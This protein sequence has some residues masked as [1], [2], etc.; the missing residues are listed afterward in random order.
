MPIPKLI[1]EFLDGKQIWYQHCTHSPA[2]TAQGTA[3][4]QHISGKELAK[5]VMIKA[6]VQ[7][8]MAVV[9]ANCRVDL[10]KLGTLLHSNTIHAASEDEFKDIFPDCELGAMPPL[11]NLYHLD[12]WMDETFHS[13]SG[14]IFN[15]GTHAETI[16]MSFADFE[17][18]VQPKLGGFAVLMH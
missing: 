14:I 3:H 13:H 17:R 2:Y 7:L 4:A 6:D 9:P 16:Q 1:S 8:L 10:T 18:L 5:V 12:V 15:A 11:G